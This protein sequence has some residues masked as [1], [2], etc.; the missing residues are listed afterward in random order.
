M[1]APENPENGATSPILAIGD[2]LL[3]SIMELLSVP[4]VLSCSLV[5]LLIGY[6]EI[7]MIHS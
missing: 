4:D 7:P 3:L 2:E 1:S 5:S 6:E